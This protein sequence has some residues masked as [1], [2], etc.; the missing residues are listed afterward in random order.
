MKR[1]LFR[2]ASFLFGVAAAAGIM[3]IGKTDVLA[4]E[5]I[6]LTGTVA[7]GTT[8]DT[9]YL[10]N[11]SNGTYELK[12]DSN[13]NFSACK[14]L[15]VGKKVTVSMYRGDDANMHASAVASNEQSV[16]V[17]VDTSNKSTVTGK[18]LDK[19]S[20]DLL[21]LD[22]SDGEMQIKIDS[23]TDLSAC[24]VLVTN[25]KATV[26]VARGSDAYMHAISISNDGSSSGSSSSS[27]SS[28]VS[29]TVAVTGTPEDKFDGNILN[30]KT[31][32][33]TYTLKVDSSTD[34]SS[35]FVFTPDNKLTVYIYRGSDAY[36]HAAKTV[37]TRS[38]NT[39]I[40]GSSTS[41][42]GTV[43]GK[44]DDSQLLLKTSGGTMTFRLDSN[45]T[46]QGAKAI[47]KGQSVTVTGA[48]GSD[49][50]W[51]AVTITAK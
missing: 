43:D 16:G 11:S 38:S 20:D 42:T 40:N 5:M 29:N 2:A 6:T 39:T 46:L 34:T 37:G 23:T 48:V 25:A 10:Y 51:H 35:G 7:K 44:S 24:R 13:T 31:K 27:S 9:L 47:I 19:S 3:T 21:Y 4:A 28:A 22:T 12:I 18:I 26:V 41:F 30:L 49:T 17:S 1:Y 15:T 50:Y 45:T 14:V 8:A 36:M 33:G 32:D